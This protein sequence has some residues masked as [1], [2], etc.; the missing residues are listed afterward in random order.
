MPPL[1]L[2]GSMSRGQIFAIGLFGICLFFWFT[3]PLP[4]SSVIHFG[5]GTDVTE[6]CRSLQEDIVILKKLAASLVSGSPT[7]IKIADVSWVYRGPDP[8]ASQPSGVEGQVGHILAKAIRAAQQTTPVPLVWDVGANQGAFTALMAAMGAQVHTFEPQPRCHAVMEATAQENSEAFRKTITRYI[9]GLG[10]RE[11]VLNIGTDVCDPGNQVPEA[12]AG[13]A[14][15]KSS[16]MN[17]ETKTASTVQVPIRQLSRILPGLDRSRPFQPGTVAIIK[18]DTEGSEASILADILPL[19]EAGVAKQLVVEVVP[20]F[21]ESRGADIQKGVATMERLA[22][23]S[24]RLVLLED[25]DMQIG[26]SPAKEGI[27]GVPGPFYTV[28]DMRKF[29]L[30]DRLA[31]KRGCNMWFTFKE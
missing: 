28:S 24:S 30:E 16:N 10:S 17:K 5:G 4:K 12:A 13:G 19:L 1:R 18:M 9:M 20:F 21:W 2:P 3:L 6:A 22:A 14:D 27:E 11:G 15:M 8:G 7:P 25:S 31:K 23:I 29:L 26:I